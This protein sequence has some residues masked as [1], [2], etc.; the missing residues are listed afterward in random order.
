MEKISILSRSSQDVIDVLPMFKRIF[1]RNFDTE[2]RDTSSWKKRGGF[3]LESIRLESSSFSWKQ[4]NRSVKVA[5][6]L[7]VDSPKILKW[8]VQN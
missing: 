5:N 3:K 6:I 4:R 2:N 7:K 1:F 8:T